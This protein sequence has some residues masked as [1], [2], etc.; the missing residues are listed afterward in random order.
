MSQDTSA[1]VAVAFTEEWGR[2]VASLIRRTG[3][4]DLA[5]ECAQ[6]AFAEAVGAGPMM[7]CRSDLGRG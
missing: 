3:D 5:A 6:Q 2:I 7:V 1:A 4:W